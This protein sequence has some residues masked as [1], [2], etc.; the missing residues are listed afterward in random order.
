MLEGRKEEEE[1]N[2][3]EEIEKHAKFYPQEETPSTDTW[4]VREAT[5]SI[6]YMG[7]D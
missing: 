2:Q 4:D 6:K 7:I 5:T 3:C 1:R